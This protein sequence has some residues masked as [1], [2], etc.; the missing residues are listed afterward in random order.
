MLDLA[1]VIVSWNVRDYLAECL[2][3]IYADLRRSGL[4][5][6]VWVVDNGSTDGTLALLDDIFLNTHVIKNQH[7]VGFGA[8]NNQGMRAAA[9]LAPRHFLLLNPDTIIRP[10]ALRAMVRCLDEQPKAGMVGPR[11]VYGDGRFQHSAFTF[12]GVA[13]LAFDLWPLPGRLYDSRLNG[14]YA[15][16]QYQPNNAPFEVDF[17]LGAA[18]LVRRDVADR[19]DGF[20]EDFHMYCEEIDWCRRIRKAGWRI[21][22]VPAAEI[23]HDGGSS[24]G[25]VPARSVVN[26]WAS[27]S[28]LYR[29]HHGPLRLA[30]ARLLVQMGLQRK[31]EAAQDAALRQAYVA[32]ADFWHK[33]SPVVP[34][35]G[36]TVLEP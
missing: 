31:A 4:L 12:P 3:S 22:T 7:N 10:G 17:I 1:V 20:D 32:A 28:Q 23:V 19:T 8:A 9:A 24:T 5:G 25:Q 30:M 15:R 16:R 27:R 14:R 33:D 13:Q 36:D 18:M 34:P 11:L 35:A 26:L 21:Y 6:E 2:A 29:R